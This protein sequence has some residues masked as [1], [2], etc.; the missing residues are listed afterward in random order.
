MNFSS[1]TT[2]FPNALLWNLALIP[3]LGLFLALF[4]HRKKV[5]ERLG[6]GE[7]TALFLGKAALLCLAWFF[8]TLCVAQPVGVGDKPETTPV[9]QKIND[10][11]FLIDASA[12]MSVADTRTDK[13]RLEY[14]KEI[15]DL[16]AGQL[17]GDKVTLYAFTSEPV[18][19]VP[20]TFNTPFLR[21]M[22]DQIQINEGGTAGT[23]FK[24]ALQVLTKGSTTLIFSDGGDTGLPDNERFK[25]IV[26]LAK[27]KRV[28]TIGLGAREESQ[29]PGLKYLNQPVY[30]AENEELLKAIAKEGQGRYYFANQMTALEIAQDIKRLIASEESYSTSMLPEL[31]KEHYFQYP[32]FVAL[33]CL[34]A[35]LFIPKRQLA[36]ILLFTPLYG[37]GLKQAS[38][39]YD[40]G[41]YAKAQ[42][43]YEMLLQ[44][45]LS[46]WQRSVVLYNLATTE[47]ADGKLENGLVLLQTA[48]PYPLLE[49][50]LSQN[51]AIALYRLAKKT[52][53]IDLYQAALDKIEEAHLSL[54]KL[55]AAIKVS[56]AELLEKEPQSAIQRAL[57]QKILF[58]GLIKELN[59]K[60]PYIEKS[61]KAL[62]KGDQRLARLYLMEARQEVK[63]SEWKKEKGSALQILRQAIEEQMHALALNRYKAPPSLLTQA[64]SMVVLQAKPF[65]PLVFAEQQEE[66]SCQKEP[67]DKALP[68]FN[69]GFQKAS[70]ITLADQESVLFDWLA[71]YNLINDFKPAPETEESTLG[72]VL[73]NLQQMTQEDTMP[74]P[75]KISQEEK[76]W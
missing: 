44:E 48:T 70:S 3:M 22:L 71:A 13:T 52:S 19:L 59:S 69:A 60:S 5:E 24:N 68:L 56:L 58:P 66:N 47:I 4:L 72:E 43:S 40:A 46:P 54:P 62:E 21:F 57:A 18:K 55:E 27:G 16:T 17:N 53:S 35:Y 38:D 26:S 73:S 51:E 36:L 20:E 30:S 34:I 23:D 9:E 29:I 50:N 45:P 31:A 49:K 39:Y 10:V 74:K 32:L 37:N 42:N 14:A 25:E 1:L 12:S 8:L 11:T 15:A 28:F 65:L 7:P 64:A 76:P 2:L 41:E 67:W 63:R 6:A 33:A 61:L 75:I